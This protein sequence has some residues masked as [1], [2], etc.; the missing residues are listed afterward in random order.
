MDEFKMVREDEKRHVVYLTIPVL[1]VAMIAFAFE[2]FRVG[3]F[4]AMSHQLFMNILTLVECVVVIDSLY[5]AARYSKIKTMAKEWY[6]KLV[7]AMICCFAFLEVLGNCMYLY[8]GGDDFWI[9]TK[10]ADLAC[11]LAYAFLLSLEAQYVV[12]LTVYHCWLKSKAKGEEG[13]H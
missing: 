6:K 7:L 9:N 10:G 2:L 3:G 11:A 12:I 1:T 4:V 5:Y 8:Y 13:V